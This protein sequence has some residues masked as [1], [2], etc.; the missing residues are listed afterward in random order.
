MIKRFLP[1]I[2][3]NTFVGSI[4]KLVN[5]IYKESKFRTKEEFNK[6]FKKIMEVPNEIIIACSISDTL[7]R[8]LIDQGNSAEWVVRRI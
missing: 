1:S 8:E 4:S 6:L 7:S 2:E 5:K 3:A